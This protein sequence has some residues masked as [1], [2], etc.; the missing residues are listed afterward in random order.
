MDA[1]IS[2]LIVHYFAEDLLLKLFS[3]MRNFLTS[4]ASEVLIWD[5]GSRTGRPDDASTP[6]P[7]T[8]F[9]SPVNVGFA[10]GHNALAER[11]QGKWFLVINPDAEFVSD[12][13]EKLWDAAEKNPRAG[14]VAPRVQFPDGRLQL[15]VFPPYS[16]GFDWR[17][18]FWLEHR[19][20]FSGPQREIGNKL[21]EAQAPFPVGWASGACLLVSRE[22]WKKVGGFDPNFFFGGEDADFC[23]RVWEAGFEVLCEPRALLNHQAGQSL[24]REPR[25]KILFYYQKRLYYAHKH[26]SRLQCGI[27]WFTSAGELAAK[28]AV[29][30]F[31]SFFS[32]RWKEKRR[33]YAG[34]LSLLFSGGWRYPERLM[35]K[36][37][38]EIPEPV[39]AAV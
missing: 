10:K 14:V 24:E 28:W 34:A 3:S 9:P 16:F 13:L 18:S 20:L 15:S 37:A 2:I 29:G 23:R 32:R 17:K 11:A 38:E 1:E 39:E 30:F 36:T 26:F 6:G 21:A 12:G 27:L 19:P 33:G 4:H 22:V 25:R 5:N 7:L 31:L 8:W 35:Q